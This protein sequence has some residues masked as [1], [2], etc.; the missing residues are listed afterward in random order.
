[1][2]NKFLNMVNDA[3]DFKY[4]ALKCV[5]AGAKHIGDKFYG[6]QFAVNGLFAIEIYLKALIYFSEEDIPHEHDLVILYNSL[7]SSIKNDL[8]ERLPNFSFYI[9]NQARGFE[10]WRYS[11]EHNCLVIS[12]EK[13][14]IVLEILD[15]YCALKIEELSVN[16]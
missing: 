7:E 11:Y 2:D 1:M 12:I 3:N 15:K 10:K 4:V 13:I 14:K 16:E 9:D 6:T 5:E 8:E